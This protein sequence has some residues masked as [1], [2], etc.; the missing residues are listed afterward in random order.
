MSVTFEI[1]SNPTGKFTLS[2]AC[3]QNV[4]PLAPWEAA[5]LDGPVVA[6]E[7]VVFDDYQAALAAAEVHKAECGDCAHYG[8]YS[9]PVCDISDD[10]GVNVTSLNA[11]TLLP[12]LGLERNEY[13][14]LVGSTSGEDFLGRTLT[15]LGC[16]DEFDD[17][18]VASTTDAA[19]G[20]ATWI[21]CGVEA[22]YL[23]RTLTR[24][25]DLAAEA[26]RLGRDVVWC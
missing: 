13:G 19:P 15:A 2:P 24:L 7:G 10:L 25:H 8:C 22:G 26:V 4:E 12:R 18:G 16:L 21:D 14:E 20:R 6:F 23:T 11:A 1:E 3:A 5:L 9:A 17:T